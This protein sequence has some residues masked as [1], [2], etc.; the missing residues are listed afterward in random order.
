MQYTQCPCVKY[1][2]FYFNI[3]NISSTRVCPCNNLLKYLL[4]YKIFD[5][6]VV[7][8]DF[9]LALRPQEETVKYCNA[10][11]LININ[12]ALAAFSLAS[13]AH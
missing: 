2:A 9:V 12:Y 11:F 4:E 10:L 7:R 1:D 6:V 13:L 5:L 3:N 8:L